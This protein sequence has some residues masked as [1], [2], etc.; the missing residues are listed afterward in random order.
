MELLF[1]WYSDGYLFVL[2]KKK[3]KAHVSMILPQVHLRNSKKQTFIF[4]Y[5]SPTIS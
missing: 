3:K 4:F 1:F 2:N 5:K